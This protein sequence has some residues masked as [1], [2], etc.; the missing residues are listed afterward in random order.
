MNTSLD[1]G[2]MLGNDDEVGRAVAA[3]GLWVALIASI[4]LVV[5]GVFAMLAGIKPG[6][7]IIV[8]GLVL[9][10]GMAAAIRFRR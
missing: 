7:W 2:E 8:A 6:V 1:G 9:S 5:I 10:A 4:A 3:T